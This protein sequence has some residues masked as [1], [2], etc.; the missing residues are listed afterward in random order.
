VQNL[1]LD[2]I[3]ESGQCFRWERATQGWRGVVAGQALTV[4][5]Q[6]DT[7]TFADTSKL[8]FDTLWHDYFD[9]GRDYGA[10]KALLSADPAMRDAISFCPGMRVLR[11]EPWETLVSF[12][13]SAN[14]NILRIRGIVE[15]LC[16]AFGE[17]IRD[18]LFSFPTP[19]RLAALTTDDL[20]PLRSGYRAAYLIDAAQKVASG[21]L[22]LSTLFHLP[23]EEAAAQLRTVKGVGPKVAQ[24][25]LLY[26]FAR[27]ECVPIDVWIRRALDRFYPDGIPTEI[28]PVAG[29]GQQ[30]LF[31]YV[32]RTSP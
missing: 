7:L 21:A 19:E 2:E 15:R 9:L 13:L 22:D 3:F 16:C 24:C 27:A 26:G 30:Y 14:N 1:S 18:G 5:Q 4:S 8:G 17:P 25:V 23:L 11:Q 31:H 10:V 32:R 6:G 28:T 29:L 12:I 20:A